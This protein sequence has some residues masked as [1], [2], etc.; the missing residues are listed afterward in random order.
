M[1][2]LCKNCTILSNVP[3][4]SLCLSFS[5]LKLGIKDNCVDSDVKSLEEGLARG[6]PQ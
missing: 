2:L 3:P 4:L 1:A 6:K 5:H